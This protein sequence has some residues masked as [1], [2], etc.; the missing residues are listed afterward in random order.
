MH[1]SRVQKKSWPVNFQ[2]VLFMAYIPYM[3][4]RYQFIP[5]FQSVTDKWKRSGE[6]AS[7]QLNEWVSI[8]FYCHLMNSNSSNGCLLLYKLIYEKC[9]RITIGPQSLVIQNKK[10][11]IYS[12]A[13]V[14][15]LC[16]LVEHYSSISHMGYIKRWSTATTVA[17]ITWYQYMQL[18]I[19]SM[20]SLRSAP[21]MS[22]NVVTQHKIA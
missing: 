10:P 13:S 20:A 18:Y 21:L 2:F 8:H 17:N 19:Y 15:A 7:E 1:T 3:R 16:I 11:H 9:P 12:C 22:V 5:Q 4:F 6:R 14:C